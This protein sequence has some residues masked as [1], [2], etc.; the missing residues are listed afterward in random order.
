M[1]LTLSELRR[2]I[3][4]DIRQFY[5]FCGYDYSMEMAHFERGLFKAERTDFINKIQFL[6]K[7]DHEDV[8]RLFNQV[9]TGFAETMTLARPQSSAVEMI[10][11]SNKSCLW[12]Q[13]K[14]HGFRQQET[15]YGNRQ[16]L[17]ILDPRRSFKLFRGI[18][19]SLISDAVEAWSSTVD[20]APSSRI[21]SLFLAMVLIA[22]HPFADADG[23]VARLF[24]TWFL[25]GRG[26]RR[27]WLAEDSKGEFARQGD[28][29]HSTQYLMMTVVS[30]TAKGHN[31][32]PYQAGRI[33]TTA[34]GKSHFRELLNSL[35]CAAEG[36]FPD[37]VI[38]LDEH[39]EATG[40]YLAQS[41][42][43]VCLRDLIRPD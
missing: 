36:V 1:P 43:F 2:A 17:P 27:L 4:H 6:V 22:I 33:F 35:E 40:Q 9:N 21:A 28:G 24:F 8:K 37:Q 34:Q 19:P 32:V 42:R 38:A 16:W 31:V 26:T 25:T 20:A 13:G 7:P 15:E 12:R 3:Q 14:H 30:E 10:L 5:S 11:E 39:L 29:I 18:T 23:R 41:P